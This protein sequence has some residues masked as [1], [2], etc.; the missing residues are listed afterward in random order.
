MNKIIDKLK[1]ENSIMKNEL[2]ALRIENNTLQELLYI[3]ESKV[4]R[5]SLKLDEYEDIIDSFENKFSIK[6][7][8]IG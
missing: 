2:D 6:N 8:N 3:S 1:S 7:S 5:L 4:Y